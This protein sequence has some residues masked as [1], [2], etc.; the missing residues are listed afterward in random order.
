[1]KRYRNASE[2]WRVNVALSETTIASSAAVTRN[3]DADVYAVGTTRVDLYDR[4]A[5]EY[6]VWLSKFDG[7]TGEVLWSRQIGSNMSDTGV[8]VIVDHFGNAVVC[9]STDGV[10]NAS[11]VNSTQSVL[12][13]RDSFVASYS[14][15]G[16]LRWLRQYGTDTVDAC[17]FGVSHSNGDILF[18]GYSQRNDV[19]D[20]GVMFSKFDERGNFVFTSTL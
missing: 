3:N 2:V 6:D 4:N 16:Q 14:P 7:L 15:T 20:F 17:S 8:N 9:G 1:M 10:L 19:T 11:D 5:G 18:Y 12:G 13:Q